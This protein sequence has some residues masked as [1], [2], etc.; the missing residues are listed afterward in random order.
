MDIELCVSILKLTF[1]LQFRLVVKTA[2]K[3]LLVFVE[4]T[5]C[6]TLLLIQAINTIDRN[7]GQS[8]QTVH[9][10]DLECEIPQHCKMGSAVTKIE[11]ELL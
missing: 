1:A 7:R 6:N 10:T 4:Y 2:L 5:E 3:L 8:A 11:K 9:L